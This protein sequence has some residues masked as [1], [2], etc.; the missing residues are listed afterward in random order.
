MATWH[1]PGSLRATLPFLPFP[2]GKRAGDVTPTSSVWRTAL[3]RRPRGPVRSNSRTP[4]TPHTSRERPR[5]SSNHA[6]GH[7]HGCY[8]HGVPVPRGQQDAAL[9]GPHGLHQDDTIPADGEA[10]AML[11]LLD[12]DTALNKT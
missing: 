8:P 6:A 5:P 12:D 9:T 11:V 2:T 10:E 1:L 4:S 7:A 3:P